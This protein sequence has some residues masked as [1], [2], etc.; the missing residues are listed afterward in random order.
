[1]KHVLLAIAIIVALVIPRESV[2]EDGATQSIQGVISNQFSAFVDR[3]VESAFGFASPMIQGQFRSPQVF[4]H[5]VEQGYPMV[6]QP[7]E[8]EFLDLRE[9]DGQT[10]QQVL[11]RDTDGVYHLLDYKMIQ[12]DGAWRIDGV[13]LIKKA[14]VGA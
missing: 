9:R 5:M 14:G 8:T 13:Q 12:I 2:A 4:G 6:W 10:W 7:T 1:M 3:D 11:V